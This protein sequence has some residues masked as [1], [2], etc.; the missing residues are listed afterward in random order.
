MFVYKFQQI[1]KAI[2]VFK[3][4]KHPNLVMLFS[5]HS[6]SLSDDNDIVT[7]L[8]LDNFKKSISNVERL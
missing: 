7:E 4:L 3:I 5:R 8:P 2:L 1:P 6:V